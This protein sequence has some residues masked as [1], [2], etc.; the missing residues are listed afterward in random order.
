M[1]Q[2]AADIFDSV[3]T[4]AFPALWDEPGKANIKEVA[5][6]LDFNKDAVARGAGI[7]ATKFNYSNPLPPELEN[8]LREW[9]MIIDKVAGHFADTEKAIAWLRLAN[10][11]LGGFSPREMIQFGRSKQLLAVVRDAIEGNLP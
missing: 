2:P 10:P 5:R 9:A 7:P 8:R 3:G 6:V 11:L 4:G 1:R